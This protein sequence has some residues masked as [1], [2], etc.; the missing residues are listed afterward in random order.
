MASQEINTKHIEEQQVRCSFIER[1]NSTN[2]RRTQIVH[3]DSFAQMT[4]VCKNGQK[5][6]GWTNE[7]T[8]R[9]DDTEE[10]TWRFGDEF[11]NY[12]ETEKALTEGRNSEGVMEELEK[13]KEKLDAKVGGKSNNGFSVKRKRRFAEEGSELNIDRLMGGDQAHW[14][15]MSRN[16]TPPIVNLYISISANGGVEDED[17][18][19]CAAM[20]IFNARHLEKMGFSTSITAITCSRISTNDRAEYFSMEVPVKKANERLDVQRISTICL[21]GIFRQFTFSIRENLVASGKSSGGDGSSPGVTQDLKDFYKIKPAN[22][23][24]V[25]EIGDKDFFQFSGDKLEELF[26]SIGL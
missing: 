13:L 14:M 26:K 16:N 17:F 12:Q 4:E 23:I 1:E 11:S 22:L 19:K 7:D 3:F 10:D 25:A 21:P 9:Y 15:K 24:D 20:A 5:D 6:F 2:D 8:F 18:N